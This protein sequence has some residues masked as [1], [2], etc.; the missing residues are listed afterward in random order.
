MGAVAGLLAAAGHDVRGSDAAV[1]PPMSEQLAAL[2]VPV[3]MP[4]ARRRT[5]TGGRSWSSS[6]T[7]TARTTSRSRRRRHAGIPLTSFPAV[8]GE[9]LLDGKHSIVVARHARQDDHDLAGRAHPDG[10]GPRSVAVRR[11]RAGR[12]RPGL[13]ARQGRRLRHRG[14]RVRHR[15]LR[16]GPEVR[17]LPAEHRDPDERRAR[18]RR[19]LPVVRRGPRHVQEARRGDRRPT[20]CSSCAR[21]RPMR[22]RSRSTRTARSSATPCS[23]TTARRR[24][25]RRTSRWWARRTSRS[26]RAAASRSTSIYNGERFERFETLLVGR[27]NVANCV[28]A[29]A[30]ASRA[31]RRRSRTSSAASRASRAC[32][33]ARSCAAS[34]AASPCSTTTRTTRRPCARR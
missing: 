11:R 15:V 33:G 22:S 14:R 10:G 29:I 5:S 19:H 18:S 6:A 9:Q 12:A 24:A 25:P 7:S 34:R 17:A 3:M 8:L 26:A 4:Y 23:T 21:S 20:A 27:H 1:Y 2:G 28:A 16:Q 30:V 31:R 13:A 32:G